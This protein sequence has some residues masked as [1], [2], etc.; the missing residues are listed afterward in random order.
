MNTMA[1]FFFIKYGRKVN[2]INIAYSVVPLLE[3]LA[4]ILGNVNFALN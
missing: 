2:H 1:M 3:I 4:V